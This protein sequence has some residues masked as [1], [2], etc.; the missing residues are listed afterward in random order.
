MKV[1]W[2]EIRTGEWCWRSQPRV[3]I[4]FCTAVA[5]CSLTLSSN[6][7]TQNLRNPCHFFRITSFNLH[8]GITIPVGT[9]THW[10][11][12]PKSPLKSKRF[13][14]M[15]NPEFFLE[16][17]LKLVK[18]MSSNAEYKLGR[19]VKNIVKSHNYIEKHRQKVIGDAVRDLT[20]SEPVVFSF[21]TWTVSDERESLY[22]R[23]VAA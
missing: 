1:T 3:A 22:E 21:Q 13:F 20:R 16:G 5:E 23:R 7:R 6:N 17:F 8:K 15:Q 12:P 4:W 9:V 11:Q 19:E 2:C 10:F 14:R 18:R